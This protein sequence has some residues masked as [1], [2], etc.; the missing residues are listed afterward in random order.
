[1]FLL[2]NGCIGKNEVVVEKWEDG[3][4]K[5]VRAH[6]KSG[7]YETRYYHNTQKESEGLV[8]DDKKHGKW[9]HYFENGNL[10]EQINYRAGK[11][12]EKIEKYFENGGLKEVGEY[13]EFGLKIKEWTT[14]DERG[15]LSSRGKYHLGLKT[16]KWSFYNENGM[17]AK[18]EFLGETGELLTVKNFDVNGVLISIKHFFANGSMKM[19]EKQIEG[20]DNLKLCKTFYENGQ[21]KNQGHKYFSYELGEWTFW[22]ANGQ[23]KAKGKFREDVSS[24]VY[25]KI[26]KK[27]QYTN[28][29]PL[30]RTFKGMKEGTW[31]YWNRDGQKMAEIKYEVKNNELVDQVIYL[32]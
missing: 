29:L 17:V 30:Q 25:E 11:P 24:E 12:F 32:R 20:K 9:K 15:K 4:S 8:V 21:I 10:K 14:Y 5:L 2:L 23:K 31:T 13:D 16:D 3:G 19:E 18:E 28:K 26:I 6:N 22:Y 1:M 7:Y 27:E